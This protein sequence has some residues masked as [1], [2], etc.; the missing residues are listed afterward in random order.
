MSMANPWEVTSVV[1]LVVA[2]VALGV[3]LWTLHTLKKMRQR[4]WNLAGLWQ[5]ASEAWMQVP[6]QHKREIR[7]RLT[8]MADERMGEW[9]S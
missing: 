6:D 8:E 9:R 5:K 2:L 4:R 7:R 3:S 1:A